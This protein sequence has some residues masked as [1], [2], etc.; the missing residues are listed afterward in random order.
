MIN[1]SKLLIYVQNIP[2]I[3]QKHQVVDGNQHYSSSYYAPPGSASASWT[4]HGV[5]N[6]VTKNGVSSNSSYD[7]NQQ[8]GMTSGNV[9]DRSS[10]TS[11]STTNSGVTNV[12][13]DYSS[14]PTYPGTD[15]YG[16]NTAGYAGYYNGYQQQPNK[17]YPQP[18]GA[19]QN[20]GAY[21]PLSSYQNTGSYAGG[22]SFSSTYYSNADYQTSGGYPSGGGYPS[23]VYSNQY[24]Q[25][26]PY[27]SHQY[28]S[29]DSSHLYNSSDSTASYSSTTAVSSS[30]YQ[31]QYQQWAGYYNQTQTEVSCAPGTENL[32]VSSASSL[33]C[34]VP[35]VSGG[36]A[37]SNNQT[38]APYVPP[39]KPES[40]TPEL[41]SVQVWCSSTLQFNRKVLIDQPDLWVLMHSQLT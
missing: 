29:S 11:T 13:P 3:G 33:S 40:D 41:P 14:Y 4:S 7:Q 30:Q 2:S 21:Q 31:Q 16:Y 26:A 19:Y 23:S 28:P 25:Y 39:R 38:P 22:A 15:P 24:G 36:Y 1:I 37:A 12:T 20:T 8:A 35:G 17:P 6:Y 5:D 9:Q 34:S 27:P 18:N 10:V 32:S